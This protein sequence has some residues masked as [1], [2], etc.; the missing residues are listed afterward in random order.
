[1]CRFGL[2]ILFVFSALSFHCY[3]QS[4]PS[5]YIKLTKEK[6]A[7][8]DCYE[9]QRFYKVYKGLT[10]K[11]DAAIE[12]SIRDCNADAN[13]PRVQKGYVDLGLPSGTLWKDKNEPGF[14][15]FDEAVS[16][17]GSKLPT[18]E[19]LEELKSSCKWT[20]TGKGYK[21][22]GPNGKSIVLPA[23][24][25]RN[26]SGSVYDVGSYGYYW[27]STPIDSGYAWYLYFDSG[28]VYI[29]NI[30]RCYGFSVRLVQD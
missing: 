15:T 19:M 25:Y 24:G 28:S 12:A 18:R 14:Y 2:L 13:A 21:V 10:G 26:C 27:S 3:A 29:H 16:K 5:V 6:L 30:S 1:M 17:F 7:V 8:G 11:K 9:A 4:D 20:W 23:A 22:T